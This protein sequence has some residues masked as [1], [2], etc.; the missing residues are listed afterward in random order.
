MQKQLSRLT[1]S[2]IGAGGLGGE[3][4]EGLARKGVG[5]LKIFDGDTVELSNLNRQRF[6]EEDL[7]QN[8]AKRLARNLAREATQRSTIRGYPL[9]FQKA[10]D[11]GLDVNGD[12]AICGVDNN[13][14]RVYVS[15]HYHQRGIPVIF[16][17]V[18]ED[19][20]HGYVFVQEPDEACFGCL[21]P[22][23]VTDKVDPCPN[24]PAVKD[25]LK[26]VAGIVL[27]AADSLVMDRRRAWNYKEIFLAGFVPDRAVTISRK[28]HCAICSSE[29]SSR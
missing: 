1:V 6:Y 20:N 14:A 12:L 11:L 2:I 28:E 5:H 22:Y 26:V 15:T 10:V 13:E 19:A 21:F 23:A 17:A 7:Y 16:T 8:K 25:I 24:T 4:G 18:S 3:I 27:Y 29:I 9:F